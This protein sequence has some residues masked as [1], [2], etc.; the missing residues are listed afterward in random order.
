M[1]FRYNVDGGAHGKVD[2]SVAPSMLTIE[3]SFR[4]I[5]P[6]KRVSN[7]TSPVVPPT[8]TDESSCLPQI[9]FWVLRGAVAAAMPVLGASVRM[10]DLR[11]QSMLSIVGRRVE[12]L[13]ADS[14]SN[15]DRPRCSR[16]CLS[17]TSSRRTK[18]RGL[19]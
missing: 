16:R 14:K 17:T 9:F 13:M 1:L 11:A 18:P 8:V 3:P 12:G 5:P 19:L 15:H 10:S 4:I 6:G 2:E 7:E